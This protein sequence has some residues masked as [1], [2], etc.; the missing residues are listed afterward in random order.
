MESVGVGDDLGGGLVSSASILLVCSAQGFIG[1]SANTR[2]VALT[3]PPI[4]VTRSEFVHPKSSL[5]TLKVARLGSLN[6]TT[7][8]IWTIVSD[9]P[10]SH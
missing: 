1:L 3:L 8:W 6:S 7:P 10:R 9:K 4:C 5:P 2:A